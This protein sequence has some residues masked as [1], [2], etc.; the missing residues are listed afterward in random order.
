MSDIARELL[1]R[2]TIEVTL[3]VDANTA[4]DL[5]DET[6]ERVLGQAAREIVRENEER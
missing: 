4:R 6:L 2:D 3:M 5:D 1:M